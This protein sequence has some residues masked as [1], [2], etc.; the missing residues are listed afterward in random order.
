MDTL[1]LAKKTLREGGFT[2]AIAHNDEIIFTSVARGVK[3]LVDFQRQFGTGR[4]PAAL[5]DKV[6]GRGA[7]LLLPL[8]GIVAVHGEVMSRPALEELERLGI[9][10]SYTTLVEGIRNREGTG[11]CPMEALSMGITDPHEML[12]KVE[13]FFRAH[14]GK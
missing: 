11:P 4:K 13:E 6:I 1:Q 12:E 5:A 8:G 10:A 3:P 9:S 2:C 14:A 7:A